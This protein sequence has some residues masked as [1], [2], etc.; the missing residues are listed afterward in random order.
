MFCKEW[1]TRINKSHVLQKNHAIGKQ[2]ENFDN[3]KL[4]NGP[5]SVFTNRIPAKTRS[6]KNWASRNITKWSIL[7]LKSSGCNV[8]NNFIHFNSNSCLYI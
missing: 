3:L 1:D 5:K 2:N 8:R 6:K 4:K 7:S